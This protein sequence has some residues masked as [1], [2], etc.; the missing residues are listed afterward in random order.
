MKAPT[1]GAQ[2]VQQQAIAPI[3]ANVQTTAEDFGASNAPEAFGKAATSI[4]DT[5]KTAAD[6]ANSL[7]NKGHQN[8][9]DTFEVDQHDKDKNGAFTSKGMDAVT[10]AP[11]RMYKNLDELKNGLMEKAP[12]Q[13][14][15]DFINL[16]YEDK[17]NSLRKQML[18]HSDREYA[19]YDKGV[20]AA[21]Q[22]TNETIAVL[23]YK[24]PERRNE[25]MRM[26]S[27]A[28]YDYADRQRIDKKIAD[29]AVHK[30]VSDTSK[31]IVQSFISSNDTAGANHFFETNKENFYSAEDVLQVK[32]WLKESDLDHKSTQLAN[33]IIYKEGLRGDV[34]INKRMEMIDDKD[35]RSATKSKAM[36]QDADIEKRIKTNAADKFMS[37]A[38]HIEQGGS[39]S[40]VIPGLGL[41]PDETKKLILR[42]EQLAGAADVKVDL[43]KYHDY[44]TMSPFEL[45]NKTIAQIYGDLRTSTTDTQF[46]SVVNKWKIASKLLTGDGDARKEWAGF[47]NEDET[48]FRSM[49]QAKIDG[50][51]DNTLREKMEPDQ[52][53][54]YQSLKNDVNDAAILWSQ[55]NG[56]KKPDSDTVKKLTD[57][58]VN[59]QRKINVEGTFW[60][61]SEK[62]SKLDE[63][64]KLRAYSPYDEI[65]KTEVASMVTFLKNNRQLGN[66]DY[67]TAMSLINKNTGLGSA[68]RKR[69]E[70]AY[71]QKRLG[72]N[73]MMMKKLMGE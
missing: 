64:Q 8:A 22:S 27:K 6:S 66:M 71:A 13:A 44:D 47:Q 43:K 37:A 68:Y 62:M 58:V 54:T 39:A 10:D 29:E 59:R 34:A 2:K 17:K 67:D 31:K 28:I 24:D 23:N 72:D 15:K 12:N 21:S 49:Q 38:N 53:I 20:T 57:Q 51:D 45:G 35:L 56:G 55:Q 1:Y 52:K 46:N 50:V 70:K 4:A 19:G 3:R 11:D 33:D 14:Q 30:S 65:P 61:S 36:I 48:L 16:S 26:G 60:D 40:S 7:A 25:A 41:D 18:A 9:F 32:G 73:S 69:I 63:S 42:Q 5:L